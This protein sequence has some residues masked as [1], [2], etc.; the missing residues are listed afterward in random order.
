MTLLDDSVPPSLGVSVPHDLA[1]QL[2]ADLAALSDLVPRL[3]A[4]LASAVATTARMTAARMTTEGPAPVADPNTHTAALL[5]DVLRGCGGIESLAERL[6]RPGGSWFLIALTGNDRAS[7]PPAGA[8]GRLAGL[9]RS[10][11]SATVLERDVVVLAPFTGAADALR[12]AERMRARFATRLDRELVGCVSEAFT[13]PADPSALCRAARRAASLLSAAAPDPAAAKV[14]TAAQLRPQL[15]LAELAEVA[16]GW[17]T[18]NGGPV[19][20]LRRHDTDR[21]SDFLGSLQAYFD[22]GCDVTEAAKRLHVHRNTLR[23]RMQ[24]IEELAGV[25]LGAPLERFTLELQ[26]RLAWWAAVAPF[27]VAVSS[28]SRCSASPHRSPPR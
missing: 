4:A 23:Y 15:V 7:P 20:T 17:D 3:N 13:A 18:L 19:E 2:V 5:A 27:S 1:P 28:T 12:L 26:V 25:D 22:A 8:V 6:G 21:G 11:A 10:G 9:L 24:R 14:V 16:G